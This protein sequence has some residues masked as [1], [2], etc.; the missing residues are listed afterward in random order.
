MQRKHYEIVIKVFTLYLLATLVS[1]TSVKAL[2][3]GSSVVAQDK[4]YYKH[5][6]SSHD[7]EIIYTKDNIAFAK[8][9]AEIETPLHNDYEKFFNWKLD[10]KLYVGLIS[11][12]NQIANGFSTQW[13]NNRQIN[14]VGGT[15]LIDYFATTSWLDTLLYH[16]STH[17][18]QLNMKGSIVSRSLHSVL[19]NGTFLLPIFITVPNVFENSFMLEGN[20]V[21]NESWHGNG[22]RLYNGRLKAET[23]LQAKAGNVNAAYAY[24]SRVAF[25]YGDTYYVVGGFYNL[26]MAEK[27]GLSKIDSYFKYHS[28]DWW[29]PFRTNWS[30]QDA[31]G[32]NF[33]KT[34]KDF[35]DEQKELSKKFVSAKGKHVA[36]S[37]FF[38][39]LGNSN[40]EIFCIINETGVREPELLRLNKATKKLTKKRSSWMS[41][42]VLKVDGKYFTQGSAHTS[43]FKIYQGLF[44]DSKCIKEGSK[45]KMVQAYLS[46]KRAVYFD[47]ATSYSQPQLYIGDTY[48]GQVNSSVIVDKE[49][50]IYYF[51]QDGKIRTLYKNNI[52]LFS[53]EG[54]YGIVSDVDSKGNI[55]FV[56][57]SKLGSTLYKYT[58]DGVLRV[59]SADNIVEARLVNDKEL[60]IAA[61]GE[62]E[63]YYVLNPQEK[64]D[65]RPYETKLF[66]EKKSYYGAYEKNSKDTLD[67]QDDYNSLLD[68]HYSGIDLTLENSSESGVVGSLHVDFADPLTQNATNI[69]LRRDESNVTIAGIGYSNAQYFL[70]YTLIGYG[71]LDKGGRDDVGE[72][73]VMASA[74]L[75]LLQTG[76][77]YGALGV[78]YFQDYDTNSRAPLTATLTL[79]NAKQFGVSMYANFLNYLEL[80]AVKERSDSMSG[81]KYIFKHDLPAEI[82]VGLEAKYSQSNANSLA[83]NRGVKISNLLVDENMDP[84]T[85]TMPSIDTSLY[86]K[87][88]AYGEINV[89]KVVNFSTYFFTFP[90]SLQRE[91]VYSAYRYYS[92]KDFANHIN[93]A[94]EV[95]VGLQFATVLL[96]SFTL[97]LHFEYIYNDSALVSNKERFRFLLGVSF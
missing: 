52:A 63:Y 26:Y 41:G 66:F 65:Q 13:P 37:Q 90:L 58:P 87:E 88:V 82:Y 29:W 69:F 97:P 7:V 43:P 22:G 34:L 40:D 96:N 74:T 32:K 18:Y 5:T 10:E 76:Y 83:D 35:A 64:I 11:D 94:N 79:Y 54:F 14:Y 38:S 1:V 60:F 31:V 85:I 2:Q 28:Q 4:D 89:A 62:R 73:G 12:Y 55:F 84:S 21:L 51:K 57:N 71:V 48:F 16:E 53:Y 67:L 72:G 27:Y 15:Q 9:A 36:S 42:K 70:D 59:S 23:V 47:V 20:A 81:G 39:S 80:Y 78:N 33:E 75:P 3:A 25:P 92:I 50:N 56:A 8:E 45:S 19:G 6:L 61:I 49:D 93:N 95:T 17:N 77:Y 30:M 44:N 24:N 86:A 68:M 46:D 91:S